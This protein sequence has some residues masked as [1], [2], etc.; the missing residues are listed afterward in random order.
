MY[1]YFI[2]IVR[3]FLVFSYLELYLFKLQTTLEQEN[4][5]TLVTPLFRH[6]AVS[7]KST[8]SEPQVTTNYNN[9]TDSFPLGR[10]FII[11]NKKQLNNKSVL[12][13]IERYPVRFF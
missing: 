10:F 4:K 12:G 8:T 2:F 3:Y 6:G 9:T 11:R 7:P 1:I 13:S 5:H